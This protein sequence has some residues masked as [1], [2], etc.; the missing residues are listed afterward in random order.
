M[1]PHETNGTNG[2]HPRTDPTVYDVH[3][4]AWSTTAL[5]QSEAEWIARA[6]DVAQIL[7]ED[8]TVRDRE[9]KIPTAEVALLKAAGLLKVLGPTK[10]GGGGQ[11]WD[12]GYR[13]IREV[14][15]RDG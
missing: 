1:S 9:Q 4:Q 5:P 7:A 6:A 14:A 8:V 11:G 13:L 10:Y 15:K 2:Y 12:V 3:T